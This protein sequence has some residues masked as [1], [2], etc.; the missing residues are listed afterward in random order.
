MELPEA[1]LSAG[2]LSG[3]TH[4]AAP[5]KGHFWS[6]LRRCRANPILPTGPL[7]Q[8]QISLNHRFGHN[9][10]PV[11]GR[12]PLGNG[13]Q[14]VIQDTAAESK[15]ACGVDG[16]TERTGG[17]AAS[18]ESLVINP[19]RQPLSLPVYSM[20]L[21]QFSNGFIYVFNEQELD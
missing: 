14:A 2:W 1:P 18:R 6:R 21:P 8:T 12:G 9:L 20:N 13:Q 7:A 3:R 15:K 11:I 4:L 19:F 16:E 10:P 5:K 17:G